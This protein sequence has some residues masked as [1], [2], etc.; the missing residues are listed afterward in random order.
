MTDVPNDFDYV[1]L[2]TTD[3][4]KAKEFYAELF[5][6]QFKEM[7]VNGEPYS[8]IYVGG[9][10]VGGIMKR[11]H[12][13]VPTAWTPYVT[14]SNVDEAAARAEKLGGKILC[15]KQE[16]PGRG[17]FVVIEDP[18]GALLGLWENK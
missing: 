16:V 13:G 17:R 1:E 11:P 3:A 7:K 18:T 15:P 9:K 6:W 5:R 12:K 2:T 10:A 4:G 14:V 8:L